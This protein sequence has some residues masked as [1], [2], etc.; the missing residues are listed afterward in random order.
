MI[1]R[2]W[3]ELRLSQISFHGLKDVRE[4]T[5]DYSSVEALSGVLWNRRIRPFISG[6]QG[7]KSLKLKGTGEQRQFWGT[8]KIENQDLDQGNKVTG[9]PPPSL[10]GPL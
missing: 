7:D 3:L 9:T 2:Q 4:L 5:F 8:G 10:G 6:E 1:Y